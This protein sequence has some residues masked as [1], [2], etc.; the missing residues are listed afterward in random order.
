MQNEYIIKAVSRQSPGWTGKILQSVRQRYKLIC[1]K[2]LKM[3]SNRLSF[4]CIRKC[5][6]YA[7]CLKGFKFIFLINRRRK[8]CKNMHQFTNTF[9]RWRQV[10]VSMPVHGLD[11]QQGTTGFSSSFNCYF[12]FRKLA[13]TST[14]QHCHHTNASEQIME[15]EQRSFHFKK[16]N[17]SAETKNVYSGGLQNQRNRRTVKGAQLKCYT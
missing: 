8:M 12:R 17:V 9:R 11:W 13:K 14:N 2:E 16:L 15:H 3:F 1:K 10:T 6:H 5:T 7:V 4:Y